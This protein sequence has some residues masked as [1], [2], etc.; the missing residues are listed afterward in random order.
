MHYATT[1]N[2]TGFLIDRTAMQTPALTNMPWSVYRCDL[3]SR[4][5][6]I[7][8]NELLI[9]GHMTAGEAMNEANRMKRTDPANSYLVGSA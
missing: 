1:D 7:P 9:S 2:Q 5:A 4:V 6:P 8:T 3:L